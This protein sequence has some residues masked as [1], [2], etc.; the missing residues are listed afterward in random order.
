[1]DGP[2]SGDQGPFQFINVGDAV[3]GL[4]SD[5]ESMADYLIGAI[6]ALILIGTLAAFALGGAVGGVTAIASVVVGVVIVR[7]VKGERRGRPDALRR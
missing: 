6:G 5:T 2:V 1:V 7:L 4:L 3:E